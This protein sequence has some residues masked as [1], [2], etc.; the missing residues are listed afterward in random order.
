[1]VG[2][3]LMSVYYSSDHRGYYSAT[4]IVGGHAK[5]SCATPTKWKFGDV[6]NSEVLYSAQKNVSPAIL[7]ST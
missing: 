4:E 2:G 5:L 1:M 6:C 7:P 3:V